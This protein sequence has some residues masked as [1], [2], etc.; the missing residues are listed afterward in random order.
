MIVNKTPISTLHDFGEKLDKK[1]D[2]AVIDD[3]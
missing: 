2:G 3:N 1:I